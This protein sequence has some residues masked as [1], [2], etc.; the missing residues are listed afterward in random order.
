MPHVAAMHAGQEVLRR[1]NS[2]RHIGRAALE[3]EVI[4]LGLHISSGPKIFKKPI[5]EFHSGGVI[6]GCSFIPDGVPN[7]PTCPFEEQCDGTCMLL[8]EM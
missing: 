8:T 1:R 2:F 4:S 5:Y 6:V 7:A 3:S